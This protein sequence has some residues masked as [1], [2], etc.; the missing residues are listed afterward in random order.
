MS[1]VL[2]LIEL[3][4]DFYLHNEIYAS[5]TFGQAKEM[6]AQR[7]RKPLKSKYRYIESGKIFIRNT[8]RTPSGNG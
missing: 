6:N 1:V 8:K 4:M 5:G 7:Q 3:Q 2:F